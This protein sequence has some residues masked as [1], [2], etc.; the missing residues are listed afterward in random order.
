LDF[1]E[2]VLSTD[3][4]DFTLPSEIAAGRYRFVVDNA[5]DQLSADVSIGLVPAEMDPV[6]VIADLEPS[7]QSEEPPASFFKV[8]FVG[9]AYAFPATTDDAIITF[10]PGS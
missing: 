7:D 8:T 10:S 6:D 9:G 3:G 2:L 4:T 5:N 1:P